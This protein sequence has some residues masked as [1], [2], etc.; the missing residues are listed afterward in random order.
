MR[1]GA[2]SVVCAVVLFGVAGAPEAAPRPLTERRAASA[3][4]DNAL[5][6]AVN[7]VRIVHLLPKLRVDIN[8]SRAAR[9]H[10]R[11]MLLHDYFAHGNFAARISRFGVRGRVFA[12]NLAWGSGV[13]SANA[14]V[15]HWLASPPHRTIL[16]DPELR[17]I[18]VATPVGAFGGFSAATLITADFAG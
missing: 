8:L 11:D 9:S 6:A 12:E 4:R 13:M 15:A 2:L 17:R 10:S 18:G 5:I 3:A 7:A 1:R 16:L 14:T